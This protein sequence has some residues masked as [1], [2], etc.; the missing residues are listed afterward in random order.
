M[1]ILEIKIMIKK[2]KIILIGNIL[3]LLFFLVSYIKIINLKKLG[4][5]TGFQLLEPLNFIAFLGIYIFGF[6]F[7]LLLLIFIILLLRYFFNKRKV[8]S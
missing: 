8:Q 7:L 6:L 3:S 4:K 2:L 1:F 5:E